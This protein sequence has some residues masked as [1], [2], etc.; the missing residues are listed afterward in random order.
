MNL[1]F[2]SINGIHCILCEAELTKAEMKKGV[3]CDFCRLINKDYLE[4]VKE[5]DFT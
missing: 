2:D 4:E 5:N 1:G 3:V